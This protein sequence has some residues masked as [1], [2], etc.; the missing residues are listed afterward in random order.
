MF[1]TNVVIN[2]S[3]YKYC[4]IYT[5]FVRNVSIELY[6]HLFNFLQYMTNIVISFFCCSGIRYRDLVFNYSC[7]I[8]VLS[9]ECDHSYLHW[10]INSYRSSNNTLCLI[11]PSKC[12]PS[13][14]KV[15]L[16]TSLT[17]S[18]GSWVTLL[19]L[20][21]AKRLSGLC[22]DISFMPVSPTP[23]TSNLHCRRLMLIIVASLMALFGTPKTSD[24]IL[25]RDTYSSM[26]N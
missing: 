20:M 8:G 25:G 3:D 14:A 11:S 7:G 10:C 18:V 5:T 2:P 4:D 13:S 1:V 16:D 6:Q 15:S 23:E 21:L 22:T 26:S 9:I 19:R 17:S 12:W 24:N